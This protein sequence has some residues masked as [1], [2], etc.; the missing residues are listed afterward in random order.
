LLWTQLDP[1]NTQVSVM[2]ALNITNLFAKKF[3]SFDLAALV[4]K[5]R[6]TH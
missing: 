3:F 2:K 6:S 5:D 4:R 1:A